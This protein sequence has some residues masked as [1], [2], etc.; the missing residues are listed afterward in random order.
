M[1]LTVV[2]V[3]AYGAEDVLVATSG[4]HE[5]WVWTGSA[6]GGLHRVSPDG[7]QVQH[8][9]STGGRPLGLEWMPDG[10]MLVCDARRGLLVSDPDGVGV[11]PLLTEVEGRPFTFCN[12][13]AV[14]SDGTVYVSDT[15]LRPDFSRSNTDAVYRFAADGRV[16]YHRDYWDPAEGIYE[17]LPWIGGLF[18]WIRRRAGGGP[19]AA[20]RSGPVVRRHRAGRR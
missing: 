7:R 4:P 15:G 10:R 2:A 8:L 13:A 11:A 6:D 19:R 3:G 20:E 12:N 5:G 17:K 14:A 1:T 18:R 16:A 9:G